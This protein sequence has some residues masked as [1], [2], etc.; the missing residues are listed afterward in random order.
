MIYLD[1]TIYAISFNRFQVALM[2][3]KHNFGT[4]LNCCDIPSISKKQYQVIIA[5]YLCWQ[6]ISG[7]QYFVLEL[8]LELAEYHFQ[9]T[10]DIALIG[11]NAIKPIQ[12]EAPDQNLESMLI[13]GKDRR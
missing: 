4:S 2:A 12:Y 7:S 6:K 1:Y 3:S 9:T 10:F 8:V 5:R 11:S 13:N